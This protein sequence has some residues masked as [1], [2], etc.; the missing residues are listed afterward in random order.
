MR[1]SWIKTV[2]RENIRGIKRS[3]KRK[4]WGAFVESAC[5]L[6]A[7]SKIQ[8]IKPQWLLLLLLIIIIPIIIPIIILMMILIIIS[9][10]PLAISMS[11]KA[12]DKSKMPLQWIQN[13][14]ACLLILLL[15]I[16]IYYFL[17][18]FIMIS[19]LLHTKWQPPLPTHQKGQPKFTWNVQYYNPPQ[20]KKNI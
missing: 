17:T 15:L 14:D 18:L 7:L 10:L 12:K 13:A 20:K 5:N 3:L 4:N 9:L 2:E 6:W 1:G 19:I 8:P 16:I 11:W